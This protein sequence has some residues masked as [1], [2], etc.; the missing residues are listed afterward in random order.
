MGQAQ[1]GRSGPS[2]RGQ[3]WQA[4][5]LNVPLGAAFRLPRGAGLGHDEDSSPGT[6]TSATGLLMQEEEGPLLVTEAKRA[7][8]PLQRSPAVSPSPRIIGRS[9]DAVHRGTAQ[10]LESDSSSSSSSSSGSESQPLTA[11]KQQTGTGAAAPDKWEA[12]AQELSCLDDDEPMLPRGPFAQ[13]QGARGLPNRR[14]RV[15]GRARSQSRGHLSSSDSRGS[16]RSVQSAP[17]ESPTWRAK[18]AKSSAS[19]MVSR[20]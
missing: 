11:E 17:S 4:S 1:G 14:S 13:P 15:E 8:L 20:V 5:N 16:G 2:A 10:V 19:G 9:H 3:T 7:N 6:C 18:S 12:M